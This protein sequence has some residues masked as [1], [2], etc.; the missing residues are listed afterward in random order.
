MKFGLRLPSYAWPDA[1]YEQVGR[2]GA[3]ARRAEDVGFDSLWVIEHLLASPALY[4]VAWHDP[5]AVLAHVA[6]VTE[7]VRLGTAIL[8]LPLRHPAIVA[9]E[10]IT[11]DFLSGGR[12]ILGVGTGWDELEFATVGVPLKERGARLD[13]GLEVIRRLLGEE[14]VTHHGRFYDLEDVSMA[15][16]PPQVP[17]VWIAGGSLGH[18]P[19]TPDKPYIAPKVLERIGRAD[20]WMSRSS[21]S[22]AGMVK[23]DWIVVQE[24]LRGIGRDP[25]TLTF[26]H[27]QFVH[28]SEAPTREEAIAEQGPCFARVMGTHRSFDDLAASYLLGTIDDIQRRIADLAAVGLQEIILTP[29]TDD[30]RQLDLLA[31][32]VVAP[33]R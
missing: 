33:F 3:Y 26:A 18:A 15:P 17:P 27:T 5:L 24:Y 32:H 19:E 20:G 10:V 4:A 11:L 6:A 23:A 2:L 28:I 16:R 22:D 9:R 29:V 12:F 1:T 25:R 7:R 21:G 30:P 31:T 14:S 13:E 8:V